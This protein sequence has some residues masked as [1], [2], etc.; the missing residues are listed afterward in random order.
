M[1]E[2]GAVTTSAAGKV[3]IGYR[4][5]VGALFPCQ[6]QVFVLWFGHQGCVLVLCKNTDYWSADSQR[7]ATLRLP[8]HTYLLSACLQSICKVRE[9][10]GHC[11]ISSCT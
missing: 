1:G 6:A 4:T 8:G 3:W 10:P 2:Q 7:A 5:D 11:P 9:R